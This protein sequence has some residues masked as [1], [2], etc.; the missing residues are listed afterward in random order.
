M[1]LVLSSTGGGVGGASTSS[2]V[3][4]G[5]QPVEAPSPSGS[6]PKRAPKM[7]WELNQN[8]QDI[9]VAKLLW[10]KIVIGEDGRL[11][12]VRCKV[13]NVVEHHEKLL[14]PK[15]DGLQKHVGC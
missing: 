4:E 10:A 15:F 5:D 6:T 14:V 11:S 8:F 13:C 12:M 1:G 7:K 2:I 3:E 9:W